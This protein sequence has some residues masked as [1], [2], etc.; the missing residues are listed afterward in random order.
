MESYPTLLK[1]FF[2]IASDPRAKNKRQKW[3]FG[4]IM[5]ILVEM[6]ILKFTMKT[7]NSQNGII[8]IVHNLTPMIEIKTPN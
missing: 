6:T 2:H 8:A 7:F 3:V 1:V 4:K 5:A